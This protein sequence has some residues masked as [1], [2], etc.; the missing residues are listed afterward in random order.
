[1]KRKRKILFVILTIIIVAIGF[2]IFSEFETEGERYS[3]S[4][5]GLK[6]AKASEIIE[7]KNGDT[8]DLSI[9]IIQ[10]EIAGQT[11]KMFGYNGQIP[12]PLLKIE[13]NSTILVN[14][15]N[16]LDVETTVHWHGLRL[17]NKFDGVPGITMD[18]LKPGESFQYELRFGDEGVYWYHPH[19]RED[20]QQEMG[21]YGNMLVSPI[22]DDYYNNVNKEIPIILDDI[23]I[24]DDGMFPFYKEYGNHGLGGRWGNI[25]LINGDDD[26]NLEVTTGEVVRFYITNVANT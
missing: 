14:V 4:T 21:L 13:Q 17:D 9:D 8:L 23:L 10:K 7:L 15:L 19:V 18:A 3:T 5:L 12:G 16:N 26:Y 24:E 2:T 20:Y 6:V 25:M 1:M 22:E 11:I